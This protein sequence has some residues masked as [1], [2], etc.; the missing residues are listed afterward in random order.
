MCLA[1]FAETSTMTD[2]LLENVFA[3]AGEHVVFSPVC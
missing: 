1:L 3:I 2:V